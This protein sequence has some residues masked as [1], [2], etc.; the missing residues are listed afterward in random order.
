MPASLCLK[1][2]DAIRTP[3]V[4]N[5]AER[6]AYKVAFDRAGTSNDMASKSDVP[7]TLERKPSPLLRRRSRGRAKARHVP[8]PSRGL[9]HIVARWKRLDRKVT[10]TRS[11]GVVKTV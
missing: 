7:L 5:S 9:Q 11:E 8:T 2:S 6:I 10:S 4:A 1:V 3:P